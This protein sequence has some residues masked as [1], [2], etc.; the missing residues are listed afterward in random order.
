MN[1]NEI[2][3]KSRN[4]NK[5]ADPYEME[6]ARKGYEYGMRAGYTLATILFIIHY[7]QGQGFD[8]EFYTIV[9]AVNVISSFYTAIKLK[10]KKYI[11]PAV[12]FGIAVI[13]SIFLMILEMVF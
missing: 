12:C 8:Y 5:K 13:G 7:C 11:I 2:L 6:V 10:E 1:K 9:L 4:E 3:E